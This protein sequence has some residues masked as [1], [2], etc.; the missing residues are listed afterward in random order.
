MSYSEPLLVP[1]LINAR[2]FKDFALWAGPED[3]FAV[4][5][6]L[7]TLLWTKHFDVKPSP[8]GA[9][10]LAA[11]A[12][13]P[14]VIN[15]RARRAPG[16]PPPVPRPPTKASERHIGVSPGGGGFG[17]KG[18]YVL[19]GDGYLHEQ[20]VA[21]GADFAPAV[22]FLP[23][24]TGVSGGLSLDG[25][26]M[27]TA[28][29]AGC[30]GVENAVWAL[31]MGA[32]DYPVASYKTGSVAPLIAMGPTVSDGV[33]YAVT[34][35]G[36]ADAAGEVHANSIVALDAT[37]KVKD[38]YTPA[39]AASLENVTPVAF[40]YNQ[41]KVLAAPGKDG[42]YVLLDAASL[43]GADHQTALASTPPVSKAKAGSI[44]ALASWQDAGWD[45]GAGF[46]AWTAEGCGEVC[47]QQWS[48]ASR[49]RRCLQGGRERREDDAGSGVGLAGSRQSRS[50]GGCERDGDCAFAGRCVHACD[51]VRAGCDERQGAVFKRRC[52]EHVC[53]WGRSRSGR[54]SCVL[55]HPRQYDVLVR[56][57]NGALTERVA[58]E[59]LS[60]FYD[61][62]G[63]MGAGVDF[64]RATEVSYR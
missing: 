54:W 5:S 28:S 35:A 64:G 4:D 8:C 32:T 22:K 36:K 57:R 16:T 59:T 12:E 13:A 62:D 55:C 31:N 20:V 3:L 7:G 26:T 41:K 18:I 63:G 10:N 27:Y 39:G 1:R 14:V 51:V 50:A 45:V 40:T 24:P 2:G 6:E 43:G 21:T 52:G 56:N 58:A 44:A 34:G 19:T 37:A 60:G 47:Q 38:W 25:K 42:S 48:G 23:G 30:A 11:V 53:A 46:G 49:K 17:I 9:T 61:C 29:R 33:A 15:F